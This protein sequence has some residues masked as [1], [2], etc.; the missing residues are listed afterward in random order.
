MASQAPGNPDFHPNLFSHTQKV[1]L[2][3]R[4][5]DRLTNLLFRT[6]QRVRIDRVLLA[7][8]KKSPFLSHPLLENVFESNKEGSVRAEKHS[9]SISA[10]KSGR[11]GCC[12]RTYR[13]CCSSNCRVNGEPLQH[14]DSTQQNLWGLSIFSNGCPTKIFIQDH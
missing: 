11:R 9:F 1:P 6:Q 10:S 14:W 7:K 3:R 13:C 2:E 8:V 12:W 5:T 4:P